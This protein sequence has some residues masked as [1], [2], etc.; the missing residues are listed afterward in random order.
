VPVL[1]GALGPTMLRLAGERAEGTI[2]FLAGPR[3]IGDHVVPTI[4]R[5]AESAGRRRPRV[6]VGLPVA[7]TADPERVRAQVAHANA[8][9]ATLPSYRAALD[10]DGFADA[11][12]MVIAGDE[13]EVAEG[14]RRYA[15]LG[16]TDALV[17][18]IGDAEEQRRTL[19]LLGALSSARTNGTLV[20]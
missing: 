16:A 13:D 15:D 1:L 19:H 12:H 4:I 7:V 20:Q 17:S 5:A 3:T 14:L 10:R 9:L 18:P 6:V 8:G 11:G 2:T